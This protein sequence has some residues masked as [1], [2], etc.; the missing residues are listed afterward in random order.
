MRGNDI[1]ASHSYVGNTNDHS[2]AHFVLVSTTCLLTGLIQSVGTVTG[3]VVP[4]VY[5][6]YY[7]FSCKY[8]TA[9]Y[10]LV[11]QLELHMGCDLVGSVAINSLKTIR[12]SS[13]TGIHI[14]YGLQYYSLSEL[15]SYS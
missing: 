11:G 15:E 13:S 3:S 10:D 9:V 12:K 7:Q 14:A 6:V 1:G 8:G 5:P 2:D 4:S